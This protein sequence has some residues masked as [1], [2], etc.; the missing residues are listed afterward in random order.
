MN[1]AC[2]LIWKKTLHLIFPS[3]FHSLLIMFICMHFIKHIHP[4]VCLH[5][6]FKWYKGHLSLPSLENGWWA[7]TMNSCRDSFN[8]ET[9][10]QN[11]VTLFPPR[12]SYMQKKNPK[13]VTGRHQVL[14]WKTLFTVHVEM[15]LGMFFLN[16]H[17][18]SPTNLL[19][20]SSGLTQIYLAAWSI[21][22]LEEI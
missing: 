4:A 2:L 18:W 12:C 6:C 9:T 7:F 5:V 17:I 13:H 1:L 8:G 16:S 3:A 10:K 20:T 11:S 19:S 22:E 21:Q 15:E 14:W